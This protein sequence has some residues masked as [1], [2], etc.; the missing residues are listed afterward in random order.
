MFSN[1]QGIKGQTFLWTDY[2]SHV[3]LRFSH[4]LRWLAVSTKEKRSHKHGSGK[5]GPAQ[6]NV[7]AK[8][9]CVRL[10]VQFERSTESYKA[11]WSQR[12][13]LLQSIWRLF[14]ICFEF[15]VFCRPSSEL[16]RASARANKIKTDFRSITYIQGMHHLKH[17]RNHLKLADIPSFVT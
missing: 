11:L 16:S 10:A 4:W 1:H 15:R 6:G 17:E 9:S 3:K 7:A 8:G 2:G 5:V 13:S 12:E 14:N